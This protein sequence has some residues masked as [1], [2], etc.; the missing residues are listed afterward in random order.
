MIRH[1]LLLRGSSFSMESTD[2]GW[3]RQYEEGPF[4]ATGKNLLYCPTAAPRENLGRFREFRESGVFF[5]W[6]SRGKKKNP[7]HITVLD[8]DCVCIRCLLHSTPRAVR[9]IGGTIT[10]QTAAGAWIFI[11]IHPFH[12]IPTHVESRLLFSSVQTDKKKTLLV[13]ERVRF[14]LLQPCTDYQAH[15]AL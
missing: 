9:C 14:H 11:N 6:C 12:A 10:P 8:D 15:C 2:S 3:D 4:P 5:Y 1:S 7:S 13:G